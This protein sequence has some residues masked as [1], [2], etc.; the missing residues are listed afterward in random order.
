MLPRLHGKAAPTWR[1]ALLRS[2]VGQVA[3]QAGQVHFRLSG[4]KAALQRGLEPALG[5]GVAR[6]LAKEIGIATEI[7]GRRERDRIDAV[8]DRDEAG[9]R[10]ACDPMRE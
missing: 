4:L 6:A 9:G 7:L 10:K 2:M 3:Q 8:L 5:L 1:S